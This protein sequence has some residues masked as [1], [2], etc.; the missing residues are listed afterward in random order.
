[1]NNLL[2]LGAKGIVVGPLDSRRDQPC[3]R[4]RP[5]RKNVPVVAVD[6]APTQGQGRDGRA[7]RQRRVRREGVQVHRRAREVGQGRADHGR[8]GLGQR[9]RPLRGLPRLHEGELSR[10]CRCWRFRRSWKGDVAATGLDTPPDRQPGREGASTCRRA[11]STWRRRCRPCKSQ[12]ACCSPA[13]DAGH[14]V[15]VS[16]DGIPQEFD[17]I[18]RARSTRPCRS[19]PTSTPST[20]CST[21]RRRWQGRPSSRARPTTTAPS[22]SWRRGIL[23]DQLPAPLVTKENVDDKALW[24]NTGQM[25]ELSASCRARSS[26]RSSVTKRFGSTVALNDVSIRVHARR[27]ACARRAQRRGQVDAGRRS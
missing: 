23:E 27:V 7:R 11:A 3:A 5:R 1:M 14:I 6:V 16:N 17:A 10:S 18:R 2:N 4:R 8:P 15:I 12:G 24:G 9:P 19:P 22:S 21:S 26:K 20:A 13:G 25:S